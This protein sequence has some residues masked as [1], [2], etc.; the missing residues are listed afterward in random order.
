MSCS[1]V[2][3]PK[4]I[5]AKI[6]VSGAKIRQ[7]LVLKCKV[8]SKKIQVGSPEQEKDLKRWVSGAKCGLKMGVFKAARPRTTFQFECSLLPVQIFQ[9]WLKTWMGELHQQR[10]ILNTALKESRNGYIARSFWNPECFAGRVTMY[11]LLSWSE[12]F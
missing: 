1:R 4:R 6:C 11:T 9:C 10:I 5:F 12:S 8:F 2:T 7:I 3:R